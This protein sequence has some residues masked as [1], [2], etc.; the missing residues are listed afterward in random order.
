MISGNLRSEENTS[1]SLP[2]EVAA[3]YPDEVL[4]MYGYKAAG[5]GLGWVGYK[6]PMNSVLGR[7]VPNPDIAFF[8]VGIKA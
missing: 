6:E 2:P 7:N 1:L 3:T 4:A 5:S 8:D